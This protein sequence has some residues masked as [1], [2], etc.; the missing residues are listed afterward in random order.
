MLSTSTFSRIELSGS[1]NG[2][3]DA[4]GLHV[5]VIAGGGNPSAGIPALFSVP[6]CDLSKSS[7]GGTVG[8]VLK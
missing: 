1:A 6:T 5:A 7:T 3:A 2:A 4:A 8:V